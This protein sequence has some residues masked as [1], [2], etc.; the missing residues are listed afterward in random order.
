MQ[1]GPGN[2]VLNLTGSIV[3][4]WKLVEETLQWHHNS[5]K[6]LLAGTRQLYHWPLRIKGKYL[7]DY[8]EL[9]KRAR[10]FGFRHTSKETFRVMKKGKLRTTLFMMWMG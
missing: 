9:D 10:D 4:K 2:T 8:K 1:Y 5:W 6:R 7:H 3:S